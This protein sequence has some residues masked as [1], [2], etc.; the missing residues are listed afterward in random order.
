MYE[1]STTVLGTSATG[2]PLDRSKSPENPRSLP[3]DFSCCGSKVSLGHELSS[4]DPHAKSMKA[5]SQIRNPTPGYLIRRHRPNR[6]TVLAMSSF[7]VP[8]TGRRCWS[9]QPNAVSPADDNEA[10][11]AGTRYLVYFDASRSETRTRHTIEWVGGVLQVLTGCT[12]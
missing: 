8:R 4:T 2:S 7:R 9:L 11:Y 12:A 6:A 5:A 1:V 3:R 10:D